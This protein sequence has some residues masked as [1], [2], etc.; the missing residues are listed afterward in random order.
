M[1]KLAFSTIIA[2]GAMV[3]SAFAIDVEIN[4]GLGFAIV[5]TDEQNVEGTYFAKDWEFE[6]RGK[7]EL[8]NGITAFMDFEVD[9][10]GA[11]GEA[12]GQAEGLD[13][14]DVVF[15]VAGSFG[16][17]T[18]GKFNNGKVLAGLGMVQPAGGTPALFHSLEAGDM[19]QDA[20]YR[21][22]EYTDE[23]TIAYTSP[24]ISG[25]TL[26]ALHQIDG[27]SRNNQ[28]GPDDNTRVESTSFGA[29][30]SMNVGDVALTLGGAYAS[31]GTDD[32][33]FAMSARG[34]M[35][36]VNAGIAYRNGDAGA[37]EY[38]VTQINAQYATGP[39]S[40][41]GA[42]STGSRGDADYHGYAVGARYNL[43]SG[44]HVSTGYTSDEN[45]GNQRARYTV[46]LNVGF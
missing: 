2:T 33:S 32:D 34:T 23:G 7:K 27:A 22:H 42:F 4:G 41:G 6:F 3:G 46:G 16:T 10:A 25:F 38:N 14:D 24:S 39:W 44:T 15:G 9:A 29:R 43:G 1:R 28:T 20:G 37:T 11:N 17:I 40:I 12:A 31:I 26:G 21:I 35:G 19:S 45:N 30:Y 36:P 8:D 13:T 5:G 18:V